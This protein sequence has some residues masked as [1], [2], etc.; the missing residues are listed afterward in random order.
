VQAHPVNFG[1]GG[2]VS[3]SIIQL[4]Q[5]SDD[6]SGLIRA[7]IK[8]A[9]PEIAA[10]LGFPHSNGLAPE[11]ES[12]RLDGSLVLLSYVVSLPDRGSKINRVRK[13]T[14]RIPGE[15]FDNSTKE[16]K[17]FLRYEYPLECIGCGS[18]LPVASASWDDTRCSHVLR[19]R[20]DAPRPKYYVWHT[21][22]GY[23]V[24]TRPAIIVYDLNMCKVI[25]LQ[26]VGR[27]SGR[28]MS[29]IPEIEQAEQ[30]RFAAEVLPGLEKVIAGAW[31]ENVNP[32]DFYFELPE[33][34]QGP[35]E[36]PR[37]GRVLSMYS[38]RL[39]S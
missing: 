30:S 5:L 18:H 19:W 36:A 25:R 22:H 2:S 10:E 23:I 12:I 34:Y 26:V 6:V 24:P 28:W 35:G 39:M 9:A 38:T 16:L 7:C 13:V 21:L 1:S 29:P 4:L 8:N 3:A 31:H 17:T 27:R 20:A 14:V 32:A 37:Q 11:P 15:L 33:E